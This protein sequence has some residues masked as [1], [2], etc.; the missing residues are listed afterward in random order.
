MKGSPPLTFELVYALATPLLNDVLL[1]QEAKG[2]GRW[3]DWQE[4]LGR[5]LWRSLHAPTKGF[6]KTTLHSHLYEDTVMST[7]RE[8]LSSGCCTAPEE[9]GSRK[10]PERGGRG[11]RANKQSDALGVWNFCFL[12]FGGYFCCFLF[13]FSFS[14]HFPLF[15]R[16]SNC[17]HTV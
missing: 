9:T 8:L 4:W 17:S 6:R 13:S 7:W 3:G 12:G 10:S 16:E 5:R 2:V 15:I 14:L 11:G 1:W